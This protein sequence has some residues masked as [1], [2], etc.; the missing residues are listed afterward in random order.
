M[1][2][3][4]LEMSLEGVEPKIGL[5]AEEIRPITRI[6]EVYESSGVPHNLRARTAPREWSVLNRKAGETKPRLPFGRRFSWRAPRL[7]N[8][9]TRFPRAA[10][11]ARIRPPRD[12]VRRIPVDIVVSLDV[13]NAAAPDVTGAPRVAAAAAIVAA[14]LTLGKIIEACIDFYPSG[15]VFL[16]NGCSRRK[17][18]MRSFQ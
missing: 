6:M 7:T 16:Q 18:R 8:T 4:F 17:R 13:L 12:G 9:A 3:L 1:G 15:H 5:A 2:N 11:S 10:S 14:G